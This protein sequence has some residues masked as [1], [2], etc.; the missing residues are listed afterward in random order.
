MKLRHVLVLLAVAALG[1]TLAGCGS[2]AD[3]AKPTNRSSSDSGNSGN[4]ES[5]DSGDSGDSSPSIPDAGDLAP[6][7]G[8]DCSA[9]ATAYMAAL[10]MAF[11][12]PDEA[13]QIQDELA[14]VKDK[15]PADIA[16][17]IATVNEAFKAIAQDGFI[18]A[19]E[20][21]DSPEFKDASERLE[22]FF[23]DGC[24]EG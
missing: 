9:V 7:F 24:K 19:G 12:S 22:R 8:E 23:E 10:G 3:V 21:M 16:R 5:S 2:D 6:L 17:D 15:V 4:G 18:A 14:K 11:A 13:K 1:V 20:K